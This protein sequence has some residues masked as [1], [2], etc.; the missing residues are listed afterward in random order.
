VL[1]L[2]RQNVPMVRSRFSD[3][4]SFGAY[5]ISKEKTKIDKIII[6]TGSEV[7]LAIEVQ[8]ILLTKGIDSRVI[9]MPSVNLFEAQKESYKEEILPSSIK[10]RYAIE[11]GEASHLYKYL[12]LEGKL[13][14]ISRFGLSGKA[15]EVIADLGFT[16]E[17]IVKKILE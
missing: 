10:S 1:V 9:S 14:N 5:I 6:A 4:T 17:K 13:F 2:T 16:P 7:S 8:K 12:G 11:M 15:E 3:L